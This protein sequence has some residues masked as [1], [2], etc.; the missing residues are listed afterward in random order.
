MSTTAMETK[1][2]QGSRV[3]VQ[4]ALCD[5]IIGDGARTLVG[6]THDGDE[7]RFDFC[8]ESCAGRF[9]N[10]WEAIRGIALD[11]SNSDSSII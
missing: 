7:R 8:S 11:E 2:K 5:E 1:A 9:E 4:C 6:S 3:Q 10:A